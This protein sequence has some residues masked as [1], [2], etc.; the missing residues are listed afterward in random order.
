MKRFTAILVIAFAAAPQLASA[1]TVCMGDPNSNIA[2][3]ANAA[4]FLMLGVLVMMFSLL[5]A[6]AYTLYRRA[7][8]PPP[9]HSELGAQPAHDLQ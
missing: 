2:K 1:C 8:L 7:K 5:G 4:I 9:P 6:F 3:G